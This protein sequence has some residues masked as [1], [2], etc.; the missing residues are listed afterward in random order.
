MNNQ[1]EKQGLADL[2]VA[3]SLIPKYEKEDY[4]KALETAPNLVLLE[5]PPIRFLRFT[6]FNAPAAAMG[7][8]RYWRTR[9]ET[10][11]EKAF[12]PLSLIGESA[13]DEAVIDILRSGTTFTPLSDAH[14]RPL[15][16]FNP[17]RRVVHDRKARSRYMFYVYQLLSENSLSQTEGFVVACVMDNRRA[18]N[19]EY[20]T[21]PTFIDAFPV[22]AKAC[23]CIYLDHKQASLQN[24]FRKFRDFLLP[25]YASFLR[26]RSSFFHAKSTEEDVANAL[27]DHDINKDQIPIDLGGN[28]SYVELQ[29]WIEAKKMRDYISYETGLTVSVQKQSKIKLD[30]PLNQPKSRLPLKKRHKP[31]TFS[32]FLEDIPDTPISKGPRRSPLMPSLPTIT[33]PAWNSLEQSF[34]GWQQY[35][36]AQQSIEKYPRVCKPDYIAYFWRYLRAGTIKLPK[37]DITAIVDAAIHAPPSIWH[38]ECNPCAFL[39][40]D[41]FNV[42]L[43]ANRLVGYWKL[44]SSVFRENKYKPM[45]QTGEGALKR[46]SDVV[47]M[48]TG[49][50]K[51]LPDDSRGNPV[52]F[53]EPTRLDATHSVQRVMRCLFYMFTLLS[54]NPKSQLTG[55]KLIFHVSSTSKDDSKDSIDLIVLDLVKELS[56]SMPVK[57]KEWHVVL[58][59]VGAVGTD[60]LLDRLN[61][62]RNVYIHDLTSFSKEEMLARLEKFNFRKQGLPRCLHGSWGEIQ[63]NQ[64]QEL[65]SRIEWK[66]PLG[67]CGGK[68]CA[69]FPAMKAYELDDDKAERVRR[70]NILHSRKKRTRQLMEKTLL[71]EE[72]TDLQEEQLSLRRE[73]ER[74][75][76][77]LKNAIDM[78]TT[79]SR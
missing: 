53:I 33:R 14:G 58:E 45:H 13:L 51:L 55:A 43:A 6:N 39:L 30:D 15:L 9:R 18:A 7:L 67:L 29:E 8:I 16:F 37:N 17:A 34:F 1:K 61:M 27:K 70:L 69:T 22:K 42:Y 54:E 10:F 11:E 28:W 44:R 74:L 3:F 78:A 12:L 35:L 41:E 50:V 62:G 21:S 46:K 23:H 75:E 56:E 66:V 63:F 31:L 38:E 32:P 76:T 71:E 59:G 60:V 52:F 47:T 72:C 77:L 36:V 79:V 49:F 5:S 64:W 68:D 26:G 57:I 65:R 4:L 24:V 48:D 25:S 40:T 2:E 73:E 20:A 19:I